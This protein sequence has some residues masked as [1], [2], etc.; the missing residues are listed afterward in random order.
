MSWTPVI[1]LHEVIAYTIT[2]RRLY[3]TT[4]FKTSN[5]SAS[6]LS[7]LI[8]QEDSKPGGFLEAKVRAVTAKEAGPYTYLVIS[9]F[10]KLLMAVVR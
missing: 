9:F 4:E 10:G 3:P 2:Y 8:P 1:G 6:Q 7:L 5:V